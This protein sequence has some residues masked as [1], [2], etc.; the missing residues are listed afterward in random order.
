MGKKSR[1]YDFQPGQKVY[2]AQ[3]DE[4]LNQLIDAHNEQ[5]D[6]LIDINTRLTETEA[7]SS[8]NTTNIGLLQTG[9]TDKTGDHSG[10][11]QGLTPTDFSGGQ[12]AIDLAGHKKDYVA[13]PAFGT[14]T[15]TSNAYVVTLSP[16]PTSYVDA[17]GIVLKINA[18]ST[19]AATINVNGLGV[20][21]LKGTTGNDITN[22]K[23][24][25]IYTFRYNATTGNF[26]LQGEG[27]D[28]TSLITSINNILGS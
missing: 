23:A 14:T 15:N 12:Q 20:K 4:E 8:T 9:K 18:N 2:S 19:G 25:G 24:N 3:V 27:S 22:L 10:T 28:P 17:M 21:S 26:I 16:A 13:H 7:N 6:T 5:D 1:K 11:W